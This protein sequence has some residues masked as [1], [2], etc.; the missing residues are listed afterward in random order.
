MGRSDRRT[1]HSAIPIPIDRKRSERASA[2]WPI[3]IGRLCPRQE[4]ESIGS[5]M[6]PSA[7]VLV[8]QIAFKADERV[9]MRSID[10]T[11]E[12]TD[13]GCRG[14]RIFEP[15]PSPKIVTGPPIPPSQ[16]VG[17]QE[18]LFFRVDSQDVVVSL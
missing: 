13:F 15:L 5:L 14:R 18:R 6:D 2:V 11:V 8:Q 17:I 3:E 9:E 7:G 4:K 10:W 12:A 1:H 16:R